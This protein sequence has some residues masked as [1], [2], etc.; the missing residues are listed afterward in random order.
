V[1]RV[2]VI[3]SLVVAGCADGPPQPVSITLG[4]DSCASCRMTL[5]SLKTAAQIVGPGREP[6]LFDDLGCL[7]DHLA[8]RSIPA[9]ARVFVA[10]HH[11][12]AWV[13]ARLAVYTQTGEQ[14]PMGSGLVAHTD[15]AARDADAVAIR[16]TAVSADRIL[17]TR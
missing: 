4:T 2:L 7:R 13:D 6:I 10:D 1:I 11:T 8:T 5:L 15:I 14:T 17:G 3:L 12:G 9:D 16:G